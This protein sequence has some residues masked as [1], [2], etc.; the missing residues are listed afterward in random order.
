MSPPGDPRVYFAAERTL[1]AWTRTGLGVI[2]LGF[3]MARFGLFLRLVRPGTMPPGG[4][5]GSAAFGVSFVVLGALV[6]AAAAWQHAR[7]FQGLGPADRPRQYSPRL[8]LWFAW[9]LA[10]AGFG[11]AVFLVV[12]E[13]QW[14]GV[15]T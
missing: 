7:F 4:Q 14:S 6:T 13:V 2:G 3:V 5:I 1:L 15:A 10:C 8:A 11:L 12:R 9:T